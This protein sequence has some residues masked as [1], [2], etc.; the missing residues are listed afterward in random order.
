[1]TQDE[2]RTKFTAA[3]KIGLRERAQRD[4]VFPPGHPQREAKLNEIDRLLALLVEIKDAA[5]EACFEQPK[6]LDA[7]RRADY[8]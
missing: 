4:R 2:L 5:K 6:L 3:Y 7:P 1:M 8:G